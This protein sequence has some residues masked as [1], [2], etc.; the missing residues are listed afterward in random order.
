MSTGM[1]SGL[2]ISKENTTVLRTSFLAVILFVGLCP[3]R[4]LFAAPTRTD[5]LI[6]KASY[7]AKALEM[8]P[9]DV[10]KDQNCGKGRRMPTAGEN[11]L[12]DRGGTS[13]SVDI[14]V[15]A[16][17]P[18]SATLSQPVIIQ[19]GSCVSAPSGIV[20]HIGRS[21]EV[22]KSDA[23]PHRVHPLIRPTEDRNK[24]KAEGA[25]PPDSNGQ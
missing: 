4:V 5:P 22:T 14:Y 24:P 19:Q 10:S 2:L 9:I 25:T 7:S 23:T 12:P 11:F 1:N 20:L 13:D 8:K 16:D 6:A 15:L 21:H 17:E 18:E 3:S